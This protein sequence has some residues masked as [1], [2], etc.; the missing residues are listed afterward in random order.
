MQCHSTPPIPSYKPPHHQPSDEL[1]FPPELDPPPPDPQIPE[2][3][4]YGPP[5]HVVLH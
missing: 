3:D 4:E 2:P 5:P 1:P